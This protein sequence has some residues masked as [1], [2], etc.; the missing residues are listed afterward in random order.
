MITSLPAARAQY[1][2]MASARR[3]IDALQNRGIEARDIELCGMSADEA[4]AMIA[5]STV[6]AQPDRGM[7][8]RIVLRVVQWAVV[9]GAVGSLFG[10]LLAAT[11]GVG[12]A[13]TN[14]G[15]QILTYGTGGMIVGGL[16]AG[17]SAI[18]Q[19]EAWELTFEEGGGHPAAV[20]VVVHDPDPAVVERA[21]RILRNK[22]AE[23]VEIVR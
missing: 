20:D 3:A 23:R 6:T 2:D 16:L 1:P 13:L 22:D 18:S 14:F 9:G 15:A 4:S 17:V 10:A 11:I 21:A 19:G 8:V 5:G 12:P 7:I